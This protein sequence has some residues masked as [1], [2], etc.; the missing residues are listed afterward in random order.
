MDSLEN[1]KSGNPDKVAF[2][3][4]CT[5]AGLVAVEIEWLWAYLKNCKQALWNPIPDA[6]TSGW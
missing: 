4:A 5:N 1:T 3:T 6:A 2:T